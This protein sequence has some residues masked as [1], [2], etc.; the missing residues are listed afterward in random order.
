[1]Q[2]PFNTSSCDG[3]RTVHGRT[4]RRDRVR[5]TGRGADHD[6]ELKHLFPSCIF[7]VSISHRYFKFARDA[8]RSVEGLHLISVIPK[9][10]P[11]LYLFSFKAA[12]GT[13]LR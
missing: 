4:S 6:H 10:L 1:V 11:L 12:V 8:T 13:N 3:R 5:I 2:A 7:V 9:K